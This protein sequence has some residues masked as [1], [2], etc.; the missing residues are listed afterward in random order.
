MDIIVKMAG[1]LCLFA[2]CCLVGFELER[3]LKQR[4]IFLREMYE[5]F[6]YLEQEM[7]C[8]R[9][10]IAEAF[11]GVAVRCTPPL[12]PLLK[13]TASRLKMGTGIPFAQ[14][15]SEEAARQIPQRFLGEDEYREVLAAAEA[16]CC[17]DTLTQQ[18]LLSKYAG[19]FRGLCGKEEQAYREKGMLCRRL[20]VAAGIF[21]V[22]LFI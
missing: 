2:A 15:W 9:T 19:H 12:G 1:L 8:R 14:I 18:V 13:Q 11:D 6:L 5:L 3:R 21:A 7:T 4:W 17:A 16:L 20:S 22:I 10:P